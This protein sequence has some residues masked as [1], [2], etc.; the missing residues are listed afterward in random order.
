[1]E[2]QDHP[3]IPEEIFVKF[4]KIKSIVKVNYNSR[5]N[6]K[7]AFS[8]P[9][10]V[11]SSSELDL[12]LQCELSPR[13][14]WSSHQIN[15]VDADKYI[16][17]MGKDRVAVLGFEGCSEWFH[18]T[19]CKFCD[20][21][22]G[23]TGEKTVR[24]SLNDLNTKYK[25]DI[26]SWIN[27]FSLEYFDGIKQVYKLVLNDTNVSPHRHLHIMAGNLP[28]LDLEWE[29]MLALSKELGTIEPL[30]KVDSY[31]NILPPRQYTFLQQAKDIGLKKMIF[32][33]EVYKEEYF[34]S[35]CPGK[36]NHIPYS[37][38][39]T[40]MEEAVKLFGHGMVRCSFVL[41]AQPIEIL[42]KGVQ[43]LAE[44]GIVSDFTVFTPK[45]GTPWETRPGPDIMEVA[46]FCSFLKGIYKKNNFSGLYCSLASRSGVMNELL[47]D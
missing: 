44:K 29:Y 17:I 34:K 35:I 27:D 11:L 20:S 33:L 39:I 21:C 16:Q 42:C 8:N 26:K 19:Q 46:N 14:K 37:K 1:M 28:N 6:F 36:H 32:N 9:K 30:E 22:A 47:Q 13:P 3:W 7:L 5:S 31:L 45:K 40:G 25:N 15:G 18:N 43:K 10:L 24:P 41:G 2:T 12:E 38:F 23:R 4:T